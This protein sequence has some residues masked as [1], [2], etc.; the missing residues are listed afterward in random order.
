MLILPSLCVRSAIQIKY[1]QKNIGPGR[2][3]KGSR[4]EGSR[5]R[6]PGG[7]RLEKMATPGARLK[8]SWTMSRLEMMATIEQCHNACWAQWTEPRSCV[9]IGGHCDHWSALMTTSDWSPALLWSVWPRTPPCPQRTSSHS[10]KP[11]RQALNDDE[12]I[13]TTMELWV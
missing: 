9:M 12:A 8:C 7:S 5:R 3:V 4:W 6:T 11:E 10:G 2:S 1:Y 13:C